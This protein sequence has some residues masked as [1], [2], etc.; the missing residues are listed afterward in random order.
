VIPPTS[1]R[2]C[3]FPDGE[4]RLCLE[5]DD[6]FL[7]PVVRDGSTA[8]LDATASGLQA[9]MRTAS[10][11]AVAIAAGA[12]ILVPESTSLDITSAITIEAW[13]RPA[14]Y[15]DA[16]IVGNLG[17]Y[18]LTITD[19][20]FVSCNMAGRQVGSYS[21]GTSIPPNQWRHV[22]CTFDGDRVRVYVDGSSSD[23]QE[24]DS[25]ISK[26]GTAGTRIAANFRGDIDGVRIYSRDLGPNNE[27]CTHA[28]KTSCQRGC[29]DGGG[30]GIGF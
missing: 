9:T 7:S 24:T 2:T 12:S 20:G 25:M 30:I 3:A 5:F 13:I 8:Q 23:C 4:L 16:T 26:A 1:Q 19:A 21:Q 28:G 10:D 6:G 17:Q 22:A 29:N 11:P 27:L 15:A 18:A 14:Q